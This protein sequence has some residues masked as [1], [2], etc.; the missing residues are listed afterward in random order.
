MKPKSRGLDELG[1]ERALDPRLSEQVE[2]SIAAAEDARAEAAAA[3]G[4]RDSF[5]DALRR[6][7][8]DLLR[9]DAE[10]AGLRARLAA[11][12]AALEAKDAAR[13][14][15][16]EELSVA[17]E[18]LQASAVSLVEANDT[19]LRL[20]NDLERRVRRRWRKAKPGS[21]PRP[22]PFRTWCGPRTAEACGPGPTAAGSSTPA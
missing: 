9:R 14:A 5:A 1:P 19:L 16:A 11:A 13:S 20:N 12:E 3:A 17:M 8:A 7:Q 4:E 15:T 21:V 2:Q 18:E 22:T 6:S 10:M